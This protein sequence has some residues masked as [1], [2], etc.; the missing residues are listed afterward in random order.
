V[1]APNRNV[2]PIYFQTALTS[3]APWLP[4]VHKNHPSKTAASSRGTNKKESFAYKTIDSYARLFLR[5]RVPFWGGTYQGSQDCKSGASKAIFP[6]NHGKA[7]AFVL[8]VVLE[9]CIP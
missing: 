4:G 8:E 9:V 6:R 2:T 5:V 3:G 7:Y 1:R